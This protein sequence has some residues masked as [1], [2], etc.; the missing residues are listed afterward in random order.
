MARPSLD[1]IRSIRITAKGILDGSDYQWGHMG[2]CN[3]G[4]LAQE[5]TKLSKSQIHEFAMERSG[6][7]AQQ[8]SSYCPTSGFPM[9]HLITLMLESGLELEDLKHLE[10]LSDPLVLNELPFEARRLK[11]NVRQDVR[12]YMWTWAELLE[13]HLI[14]HLPPPSI[15]DPSD[16]LLATQ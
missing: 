8:C 11:R 15:E 9:D 5:I 16:L 13:D 7:W 4:L 12:L 14:Q 1:L 6:D 3:C 10:N 2:C